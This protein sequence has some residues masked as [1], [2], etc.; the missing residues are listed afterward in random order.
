MGDSDHPHREAGPVHQV[1]WQ[2]LRAP[3]HLPSGQKPRRCVWKGVCLLQRPTG[4]RGGWCPQQDTG[5]GRPASHSK[6]FCIQ[7]PFQA[8]TPGGHAGPAFWGSQSAR[9]SAVWGLPGSK[10]KAQHRPQRD[11]QNRVGALV[12]HQQGL[13][14]LCR[15]LARHWGSCPHVT[16]GATKPRCG[17]C[18]L[19]AHRWAAWGLR[20][21]SWRASRGRQAG[22]GPAR[23][24]R[25]AEAGPH[26]EPRPTATPEGQAPRAGPGTGPRARC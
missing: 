22:C 4:G 13:G 21:S 11:T 7:R 9:V 17:Q 20:H 25:G 1:L 6:C 26:K 18:H 10:I 8:P 15:P 23:S 3:P 12:R 16:T 24:C 14:T 19:L 2:F 5:P